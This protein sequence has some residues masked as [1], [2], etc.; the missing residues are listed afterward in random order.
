MTKPTRVKSAFSAIKTGEDGIRTS[1]PLPLPA[2][3][4][5]CKPTRPAHQSPT[6][7]ANGVSANFPNAKAKSSSTCADLSS[8]T[9]FLEA[10]RR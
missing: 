7:S 4:Q 3:L 9:D 1:I 8:G 6:Q 10:N 5:R 2:N